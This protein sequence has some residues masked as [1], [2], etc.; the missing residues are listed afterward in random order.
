M[1]GRGGEVVARGAWELIGGRA[2]NLLVGMA[3]EDLGGGRRGRATSLGFGAGIGA[4]GTGIDAMGAVADSRAATLGRGSGLD[5][6]ADGA[7][8]PSFDVRRFRRST[9]T[10]PRTSTVRAAHA[11]SGERTGKRGDSDSYPGA[12]SSLSSPPGFP[13]ACGSCT[14]GSCRASGG[15]ITAASNPG[16]VSLDKG[17]ALG[18]A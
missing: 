8:V 9:P 15:G 5:A 17:T 11:M 7:V 13:G 14:V 2:I 10:A 4:V 18:P 16:C 1:G 3:A 6:D 12:G